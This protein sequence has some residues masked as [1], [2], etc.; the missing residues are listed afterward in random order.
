[1]SDVTS[2]HLQ[3]LTELR[4]LRSSGSRHDGQPLSAATMRALDHDITLLE[5][6]LSLDA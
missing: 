2:R 5:A 4:A 3:S 1:M 6:L